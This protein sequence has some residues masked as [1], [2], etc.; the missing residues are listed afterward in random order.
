MNY[1]I[2]PQEFKQRQERNEELTLL[3]VRE[4]WER[5]AAS[6]IAQPASFPWPT[7]PRVCRN[8]TPIS[9]SSSTVTTACAR[10]RSPAGCA[11]RATRKCNPFAG[12]DA[13]A[14]IDPRSPVLAAAD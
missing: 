9:T 14:E 7:F 12:I 1:E 3:D 6:I 13:G 2:T 4:P 5:Q 11:S 8:S 10:S